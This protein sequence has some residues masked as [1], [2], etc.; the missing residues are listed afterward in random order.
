MPF[1]QL[2]IGPAGSGKT[3]F[4]HGMQQFL[5]LLGRK[6]VVV[7]LDPANGSL[8]YDCAVDLAD[9]VSLDQVM[10]N[11]GLGPNGGKFS[12]SAFA[13]WTA[14][15]ACAVLC[16]GSSFQEKELLPKY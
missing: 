15:L 1:G 10:Q 9:L 7:N 12:F 13:S 5:T 11:L 2:V 6:A 8:P 14:L 3:T 4:C 16:L